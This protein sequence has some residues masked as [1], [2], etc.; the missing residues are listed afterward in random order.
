MKAKQR[1][2]TAFHTA[3]SNASNKQ[4]PFPK[5]NEKSLW[6]QYS[7]ECIM[8]PVFYIKADN[9]PCLTVLRR[10]VYSLQVTFYFAETFFKP[11]QSCINHFLLKLTF[12]YRKYGPTKLL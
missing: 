3:L 11:F 4:Q 9:M 2:I 12:P 8:I 6:V 5:L 10:C 1:F 7:V